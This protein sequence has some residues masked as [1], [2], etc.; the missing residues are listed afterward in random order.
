MAKEFFPMVSG[1]TYGGPEC[2]DPLKFRWYNADEVIY[3][4]RMRDHLK[5]AVCFWHTFRW[6]GTDPF[7]VATF[8]RP[9]STIDAADASIEQAISV[10]NH[11][12]DAAFEFLSKLGV[13]YYTF[14]DRDVA[15]EGRT[16]QET[17]AILDAVTDYML[18]KQQQTGIKLLWGTANL[19]SHPRY[20]DGAMTSPDLKV[21]AHAAAQ[22]KK[23]MEVTNKLGGT[24]YV[25][26]G[27]REGYQTIL[28]T[29]IKREMDHMATFLRMVVQHKKDIGATFHMFIEPKPRE[30]TKHQYDYDAQ[31]VLHFLHLHNLQDDFT[32][33]IE[34]NHTTLAG[35]SY[36]HD[37]V[38]AAALGKL[39]SIDCNS[40]DPLLGWD[41]DQFLCNE[42]EA[43][44]VVK[45]VL[46][47]GGLR[48]GFNFDCKPRRESTDLEDLF[49]SHIGAMDVFARGLRNAAK[50]LET[51]IIPNMVSQRYSTW[52]SS[53]GR[54]IEAGSS[55][56]KELAKIA[57][58]Q[59]PIVVASARS[60][61]FDRV[62]NDEIHNS[63]AKD[64]KL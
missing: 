51:G 64:S 40:G 18:I 2:T 9:W 36:E 24:G 34:P 8:A 25:F 31:T 44:L 63:I 35:H 6:P 47:M 7:G 10:S 45:A 20:K 12:V 57:E 23:A 11:R 22:V 32:L 33:N 1:I 14:H 15:P 61:L 16:I 60:E 42:K 59:D 56:L 21:F 43:T 48:G 26:W 62:L 29:N 17:N 19:F 53:T 52:D 5:F 58:D 28:N 30:P 4:K 39:G 27:G 50:I 41:T 46:E 13:D 49:I 38:V 55:S 54:H 37:V 3:G